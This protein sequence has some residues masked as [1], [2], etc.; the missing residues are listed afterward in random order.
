M[1]FSDCVLVYGVNFNHMYNLFN[2][3]QKIPLNKIQIYAIT[4]RVKE[5][6][7]GPDSGCSA[8]GRLSLEKQILQNEE[9]I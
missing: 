8:D 7:R 3:V 5:E 4:Y 1:F 6:Q 2:R 9:L